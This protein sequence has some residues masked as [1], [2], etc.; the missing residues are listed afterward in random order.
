MPN[1]RQ[2]KLSLSLQVPNFDEILEDF[3]T[4]KENQG[5]SER[6]VNDYR[7]HIQ[8]FYKAYPYFPDIEKLKKSANE[9]LRIKVSASAY[10][11]K[12]TYNKAFFTYCVEKGY[13]SENPMQDFTVKK[14]EAKI[15]QNSI[16]C[17][18][19][20]LKQPDTN[21]FVGLRDYAMILLTLDTGI[22]PS[23][24]R[25]LMPDDF[26]SKNGMIIIPASISKVRK[27]RSLPIQP[28]TVS[29]IRRL[30][31]CKPASWI[32]S[33]IFCTNEGEMMLARAWQDRIK[34]YSRRIGEKI[35]PYDLRHDFALLYL[36]NGGNVF[37]LQKMMGHTT[38][39]MTRRY[40]DIDTTELKRMASIASPINSIIKSKGR[41]NKIS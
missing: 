21:T 6:T 5:K 41:M 32:N 13:L 23:E 24:I 40:I 33:P 36:Q 11:L 1:K 20:L 12:L 29:I 27:S 7:Y 16:E 26:D 31:A 38:L 25:Q 14:T 4:F 10:N 35:T 2:T 19:E 15:V 17:L 22:R 37:T 28:V 9:Y 8:R 34:F 3:L 30:Q 39:E 18:S